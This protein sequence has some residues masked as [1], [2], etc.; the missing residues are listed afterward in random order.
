M[1]PCGRDKQTLRWFGLTDGWYRLDLNGHQLLRYSA[2]T[3]RRRRRRHRLRRPGTRGVQLGTQQFTD[4]VRDL[5]RHPMAA[6][7]AAAVG[8]RLL[9][10]RRRAGAG[11]SRVAAD[12]FVV[13]PGAG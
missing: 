11:V 1:H 3:A 13:R 5:D 9:V 10:V 8:C 12:S 2:E 4:A 6:M 7:N